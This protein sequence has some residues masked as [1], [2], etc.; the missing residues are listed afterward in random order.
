MLFLSCRFYQCIGSA[1]LDCLR[2]NAGD[3]GARRHVLCHD[4]A[5]ADNCAFPNR[6]AGADRHPRAKPHLVSDHDR[7]GEHPAALLGIR[8]VVERRDD[9]L[10][11]DQHVVADCDAAL[12]LELTAR[13]DEHALAD[14]RVLSAIGMERRE[15]T[16]RL[17]DLARRQLDRKSVV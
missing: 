12:V 9:R 4:R 5:R 8:I 2:R 17:V 13:V 15:E 6:H 11:T 7:L 10:R 3:D 14:L 1:L 16:E